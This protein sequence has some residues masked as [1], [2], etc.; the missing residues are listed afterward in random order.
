[1]LASYKELLIIISIVKT[2]LLHLN[3]IVTILATSE[4]LNSNFLT[5][6]GSWKQN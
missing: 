4:N 5:I 6:S 3:Y 1:M 2:Y